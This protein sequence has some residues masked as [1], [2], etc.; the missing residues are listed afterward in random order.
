MS[1]EI[2]ETIIE[3]EIKEPVKE[4][5]DPKKIGEYLIVSAIENTPEKREDLLKSLKEDKDIEFIKE[6]VHTKLIKVKMS[7]EKSLIVKTWPSILT[8]ADN[9]GK[10]R[11]EI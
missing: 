3:N 8:V 2:V 11:L 5:I 1:E 9:N 4:V 7:L 6:Y 10:D